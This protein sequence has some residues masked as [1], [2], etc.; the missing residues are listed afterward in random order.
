[1]RARDA[2]VFPVFGYRAAGYLDALRLQDAGNLLVGQR[3]AGIL[4]FDQLFDA[5][6]E[7]EQRCAA[8]LGALS[9]FR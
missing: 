5:A 9:R 3:T 1:M 6:L 4:F 2:H 8:A 7:D